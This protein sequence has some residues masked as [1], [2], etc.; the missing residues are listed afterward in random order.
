[1]Y[2]YTLKWDVVDKQVKKGDRF[3]C[4]RDVVMDTGGV[5]YKKGWHYTS[6]EDGCI[7]G[8][9]GDP[10]HGWPVEEHEENWWDYFHPLPHPVETCGCDRCKRVMEKQKH[11]INSCDCPKCNDWSS[12]P[13]KDYF[14]SMK[15]EYG[16]TGGSS[17]PLPPDAPT[18][19]DLIIEECEALKNTLL[20]K[21][22]KY[23]DSATRRGHLF[24]M[25]PVISI[26]ARIEDK[27]NRLKNDN[28]DEDEDITADILG[29]FVLLRIAQKQEREATSEAYKSM[30]PGR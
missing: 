11:C 10:D 1:M 30:F 17:N 29:Y 15:E 13:D 2:Q 22:R 5:N 23:G 16:V 26:K 14:Q 12:K 7:T 28:R 24:N 3:L 18:T 4:K 19:E 21:N 25:S 27:L 20:E 6:D 9:N 8:E